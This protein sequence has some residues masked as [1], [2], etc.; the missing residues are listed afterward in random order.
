MENYSVNK[1]KLEMRDRFGNLDHGE[2]FRESG[3]E[4]P[5]TKLDGKYCIVWYTEAPELGELDE[6]TPI[7]RIK[8]LKIEVNWDK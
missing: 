7:I 8:N 5:M 3:G 1:S 6:L 4:I 2:S